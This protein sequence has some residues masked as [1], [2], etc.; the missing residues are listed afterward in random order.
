MTSAALDRMLG[1]G[2]LPTL[3][4]HTISTRG[5]LD[6]ELERVRERGYAVDREET[7]PGLACIGV[8]LDLPGFRSAA[9]SVSGPAAEYTASA[10]KRFVPILRRTARGLESSVGQALIYGRDASASALGEPY[11]AAA[12]HTGAGR[13]ERPPHLRA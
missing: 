13:K 1:T 3:T 5:L 8:A 12:A 4:T 11:A 2:A 6:K 9:I 10:E 7:E